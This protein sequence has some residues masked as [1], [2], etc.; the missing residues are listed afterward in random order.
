MAR[1][2]REKMHMV[3]VDEAS[4]FQTNPMP[5]ML[6]ESRKFGLSMV[7][8][9]QHTGQLTQEIRDALEANYASFSA[10]RLSSKDA[11]NAA[12][13]F[14]DSKMQVSLPRLD[15]FRAMTTLNVD[16][17]QTVPFTLEVSRPKRQKNADELAAHIE[18]ESIQKLVEPYRHLRALTPEEI[19]RQLGLPEK[20]A[21]NLAAP[22]WEPAE[23]LGSV[24]LYLEEWKKK[25]STLKKLAEQRRITDVRV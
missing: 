8:C 11:A 25:R 3:V 21:D 5:R 10:F 13:R 2:D 19:K 22:S 9:H 1:H 14:D 12:I 17:K 16:G 18:H 6:A 7:L 15:A 24:P 4:L 20:E 23:A